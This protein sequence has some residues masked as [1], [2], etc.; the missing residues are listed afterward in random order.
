MSEA[1]VEHGDVGVRL[2]IVE[3]ELARYRAVFE[4]AHVG[5]AE[6]DA[7]GLVRLANSRL[8]TLLGVLPAF[9]I[10]KPLLHFVARGDTRVFRG[11]VRSLAEGGELDVVLRLRPR[12]RGTPFYAAVRA[13][14]AR[15]GP[16]MYLVWSVQ[17]LDGRR[18]AL[19]GGAS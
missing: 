7:H 6:T 10:G 16:A 15:G 2:A 9:V 8:A 5:L 4:A 17:A 18:S 3:A 14:A 13:R 19:H 12:D 1:G 11:V